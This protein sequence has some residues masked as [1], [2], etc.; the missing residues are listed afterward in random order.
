MPSNRNLPANRGWYRKARRF[1]IELKDKN[2]GIV[3]S[4]LFEISEAFPAA[5][6]LLEY[7]DGQASYTGK[8][9]IRAISRP[10][11]RSALGRET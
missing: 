9:V 8:H 2:D 1:S 11:A 7:R 10:I 5:I 4:H 6:F 3:R